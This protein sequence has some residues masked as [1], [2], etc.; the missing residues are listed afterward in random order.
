[1][2]K[3]LKLGK[4][5]GR[6][7]R[8]RQK[9]TWLDSITDSVGMNLSELQ[10]IME[11][12]GAWHAVVHGVTKSRHNLQTEQQ[13][14]THTNRYAQREETGSMPCEGRRLEDRSASLRASKIDGKPSQSG[15]EAP[16]PTLT[17]DVPV[18]GAAPSP[19]VAG[20]GLRI[21]VREKQHRETSLFECTMEY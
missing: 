14:H 8:K 4:I 5:E 3:T 19:W 10:E 16:A 17:W 1:M 6:R 18:W 15:K 12:R 9:M 21:T 7:R 13:Q 2:K 11:D 20:H